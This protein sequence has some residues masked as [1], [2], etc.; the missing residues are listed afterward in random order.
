MDNPTNVIQQTEMLRILSKAEAIAHIGSWKWDFTT[1][2]ITW[3][4]EML[5]ILLRRNDTSR[6]P[7][8]S[9]FVSPRDRCARAW[10]K[11]CFYA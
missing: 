6:S 3:S 2:R 1:N 10:R 9:C 5:T 11:D 4:D 8:F 7:A